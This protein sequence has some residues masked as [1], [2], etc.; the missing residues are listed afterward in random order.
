MKIALLYP[1]P[2]KI[3]ASGDAPDDRDG[4]PAEYVEGDLDGDR[5]SRVAAHLAS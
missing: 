4:P 3:P 1:P 2:W 5:V